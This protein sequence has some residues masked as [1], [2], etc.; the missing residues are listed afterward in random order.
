MA[1]SAPV[2]KPM[3]A[4]AVLLLTHTPPLT[5]SDRVADVLAHKDVVP[6]MTDGAGEMV[7]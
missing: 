6:V 2:V 3:L 4:T 7:I 5:E 1:A